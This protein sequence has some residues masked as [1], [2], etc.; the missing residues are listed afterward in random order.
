M[1]VSFNANKQFLFLGEKIVDDA[2]LV[3]WF[4]HTCLGAHVH[5]GYKWKPGWDICINFG[6][7]SQAVGRHTEKPLQSTHC[8]GQIMYLNRLHCAGDMKQEI[9][10]LKKT[11]EEIY[12]EET[13]WQSWV[14][15]FEPLIFWPLLGFWK[16]CNGFW[17]RDFIGELFCY[18]WAAFICSTV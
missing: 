1:I 10:V 14:F 2:I 11:I 6:N 4:T 5:D 15:L 8:K 7:Q 18:G 16:D 12:G 9:A 13:Y 3:D 17:E